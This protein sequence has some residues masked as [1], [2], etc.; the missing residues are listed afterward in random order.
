MFILKSYGALCR[1]YIALFAAYSAAATYLL[2]SGRPA[3]AFS[4][5][6]AV[7]LLACGASALNQVQERDIDAIMER[8]CRRPLP[9]GAISTAHAVLSAAGL[10]A[11]GLLLLATA[12]GAVAAALGFVSLLWYNGVYTLLKRITAFASVPG[13]AVGMIS[14]AIGWSAA[15]N[16]LFDARL[17]AVCFLFFMW[18]IPHFWLLILDHGEE[19]ERAGLP[20]LT[21]K[22]SKVQ[23]ARITFI[24]I[25]AA[26][27]SSFA[28]PLYGS[29][30]SPA[31]V[32]ALLPFAA[33]VIWNGAE[34]LRENPACPSHHLLFRRINGYLFLLMTILSLDHVFA[35]LL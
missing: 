19:Y 20:S 31:A 2:A 16:T 4:P 15:G 7:F 3:G 5:A 33:W 9:S 6:V 26:S 8:T 32:L 28:L 29:M 10:I 34:L 25:N 21:R 1:P 17:S 18:Q 12:C 22:M 13:A 11:A 23:I 35:P 27:I 14:P 24:W 30:R